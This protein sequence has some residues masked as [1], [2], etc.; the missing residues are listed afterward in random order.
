MAEQE[1]RLRKRLATR[2]SSRKPCRAVHVAVALGCPVVQED[3]PLPFVHYPNLGG[4][5]IGFSRTPTEKSVLCSCSE[6]AVRNYIRLNPSSSRPLNSH[7]LR[8]APLDSGYFPDSFARDSLGHDDDPMQCLR[9]EER[10]CHRCQMRTPSLRYCVPMY[11]GQFNQAYGWYVRQ[12]RLRFGVAGAEFLVD[13]CPPEIQEP[14]QRLSSINEASN[15][16]AQEVVWNV[17]TPSE[18]QTELERLWK[19]RSSLNRQIGN[20]F[21]NETRREFGVRGIGEGWVSE[22]ILYQIVA[23]QFPERECRRHFRPPWLGGLE[24]DVFVPDENIA[25]EYQGQQHFYPVERWGGRKALDA[26]RIRDAKK[27]E[28]CRQR[29]VSLIAFDFTEPLTE[30]HVRQRLQL[31]RDPD[32]ESCDGGSLPL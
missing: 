3:L 6:P 32:W 28:L 20:L 19:V 18:E 1:R 14:L 26:L 5:F 7:P 16:L 10:I 25:F 2:R 17:T 15:R 31:A 12:T 22:S 24:L 23:R 27:S 21:E 8:M 13:V 29:G 9:F 11:G 4:T 30:Q